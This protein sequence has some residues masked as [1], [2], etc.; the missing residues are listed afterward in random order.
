MIFSNKF[1]KLP[2]SIR[3]LIPFA[4][5]VSLL[6]SFGMSF[7]Y[8]PVVYLFAFI[9]SIYMITNIFYSFSIAL[10]KGLKYFPFL[11]ASFLTLHFSYGL[12]SL[13]GLIKL[14]F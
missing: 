14:L 9:I 10:Q 5:V 8:E 11:I 1:A 2:F 13:W 6:G 4:F 3:H 7:L 12:G